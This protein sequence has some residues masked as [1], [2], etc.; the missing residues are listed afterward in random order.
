MNID[1]KTP[2]AFVDLETTGTSARRDRVIEIGIVRV[3]EGRVVKEFRTFLNP[4]V[5]VSSFITGLTGISTQMLQGAPEF[6]DV[7]LE[8]NDILEGA[9]FVAHNA[10]FDYGFLGEECRRIGLYFAYPYLCTAKLSREL[11]PH[12][13]HHNLESIIERYAFVFEN[14]HRA[15]DDARVLHQLMSY[16]RRELGDERVFGAMQE[17]V[18]VRRLPM[19][20]QEEQIMRLPE[21]SGVYQFFGKQDELLYVGKSRRIRTRVRAHFSA[22]I[23]SGRGRDMLSDIRRI[24]Y[25]ETAGELGALLLESHLIKKESPVYNILG[26]ETKALFLAREKLDTEGHTALS[27]GYADSIERGEEKHIAALFKSKLQA[28]EVLMQVAREH[29]LCPTLLGLEKS[30]P[31]FAHQL[32]QCKGACVGKEK[33]RHYNKRF[34]EAFANYRLKTWPFAGPVAIEE[35]DTGGSCQLFVV[36]NWRLIA[37]LEQVDG[38]W[39]EFVPARFRFD[40]DAYRIFSRELLKKRP[41]VAVRELTSVEQAWLQRDEVTLT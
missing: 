23:L 13:E 32:E 35:K 24:D 33:A 29:A 20:V 30:A 26:R 18:R 9:L 17:M 34:R 8:V 39:N 11:F 27:L 25:R 16:A 1:H 14:R 15:L 12:E 36:D 7:A 2:L 5:L 38:E 19:F 40:Y 31:C 41:K 4:G 37:A 22:D 6:E 3:E 21:S 10:P 28:Q